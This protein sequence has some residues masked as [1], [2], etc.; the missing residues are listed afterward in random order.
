MNEKEPSKFNSFK[1]R[2]NERASNWDL[3][4]KDQTHYANFEQGYA[5]FL[6]LEKRLL[7]DIP[8]KEVGVD[9]GCGT[10]GA[11]LPLAEKVNQLFLVDLSE[12]MLKV[13]K[14]K[15]PAAHVV[16]ASVTEL[17]LD[18]GSVDI[19]I[20]RGVVISHLPNEEYMNFLKEI[21][22]ILNSGGIVIFD[23]LSNVTSADFP[24]SEPKAT[25]TTEQMEKLLLNLQFENIN[26]D[27][28]DSNRV[29]R[30]WATKK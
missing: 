15:F 29:I 22:R 1:N 9:L 13:A 19:A 2:W 17:P 23:F 7:K 3:D 12:E 21:Q 11:S 10:A 27:G 8:R 24:F 28:D 16:N 14:N 25:F 6:D 26:F 20:S 5:K 30:V 18:N 4:I